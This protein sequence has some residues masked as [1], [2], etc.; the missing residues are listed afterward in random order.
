M[1][2]LIAEYRGQ[3]YGAKLIKYAENFFRKN[4]VD[5]YQLRVSPTN[6]SAINFYKKHG[7]ELLRVEDEDTFPRYRMQKLLN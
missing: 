5:I 1:F 6:I 4:N 3:G 7:F 2:Y